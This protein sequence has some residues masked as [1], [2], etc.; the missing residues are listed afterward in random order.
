MNNFVKKLLSVVLSGVFT[1][2]FIVVMHFCAPR[3]QAVPETYG[4]IQYLVSDESG[5]TSAS[6]EFTAVVGK[7]VTA[8]RIS[9]L[10]K[11]N[12]IT[13]VNYVANEFVHPISL[14]ENIQIVDL[15]KPFAFAEKGTLIFIILNLDPEKDDFMEQSQKLSPYKVGENWEFTLSL[16]E[17]FSASNVY[18]KTILEAKHGAIENYDFIQYINNEEKTENFSQRVDRTSI[19]LSFHTRPQALNNRIITVHY[20]STGSVYSG[21]KD[22]P[23]IGEAPSVSTALVT[24]QNLLISCAV[25]T[26]V[27]IAVLVVLS[28]LKRTKDFVNSI[29]WIFG[30]FLML[31]PRFM[32]GLST[33]IPLF[34]IALSCCA[35]FITLGGVLSAFGR[36]FGK[37]PAR[38]LFLAL[39]GTGGVIA[40]VYP[41][42][43]FG[44][45]NILKIIFT[46]IKTVGAVALLA[47]TVFAVFRKDAYHSALESAVAASIAVAVLASVFA[48]AMFPVY[49][50]SIFWLCLLAV[51]TTFVGVFRVFKETE[52]A[53]AYLTANLHLEVDRQL[54]DIRAVIAERDDLLRFVSHDMKK[55]LQA[56]ALLLDTLIDREKDTEQTKALLIVKQNNSRVIGNLSEIGSYTRFNYIAEPSQSVNLYELCASLCDFHNPDCNANGII[57]K[58]SVNKHYKVF[59][60]KQGLENAVSNIILNAIEHANCNTITLSAATHK[61]K[62]VLKIEDDGQGIA[63]EADLFSP[64]GSGKSQTSGVGLYIC[65]NIVES[66][67][68]ELSYKSRSGCTSF[69]ISL[70]KT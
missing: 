53:N 32:L 51:I 52:M 21:I 41:F 13:K 10:D 59:A 43:P 55:P 24:S 11:L 22:C 62:V 14:S 47:F 19:A 18:S 66:M 67:N 45:A 35:A 39:M 60:K 8:I 5:D 63:N 57:L 31:F 58:N 17:I 25:L 28:L 65:K 37:F 38:Y 7:D 42:L 33:D 30:I 34:F 2:V 20:Q 15:T 36:N 69:C 27:V 23:L 4:E 3:I 68:G 46:A 29:V 9:D 12:K 70:L 40:F 64:Y 49:S 1:A 54:K 61:N 26:A 48:P 6:K 50:Y 16:P 44:A 56:S